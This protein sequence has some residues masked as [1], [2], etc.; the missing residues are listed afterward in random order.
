MKKTVISLFIV[1][2]LSIG[3]FAQTNLQPIAEVKFSGRAPITLGQL[4]SRVS[5]LEK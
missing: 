2:S 1:V 3:A 5:V 4:K